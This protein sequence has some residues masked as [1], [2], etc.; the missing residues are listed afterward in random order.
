MPRYWCLLPAERRPVGERARQR[1]RD[2]RW[3]GSP[4]R[5]A[6]GR[7]ATTR[8]D[9]R[10]F[11]DGQS[12]CCRDSATCDACGRCSGRDR[13]GEYA[14]RRRRRARTHRAR[15]ARPCEDARDRIRQPAVWPQRPD[16]CPIAY[17]AYEAPLSLRVRARALRR[18]AG[19]CAGWDI[20]R[21]RMP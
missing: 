20:G 19:R 16:A 5:G 3:R 2:W 12:S 21:D 13:S 8:A 18:H 14:L 15:E 7:R 9:G 4:G 1:A 11:R 17:D 10:R 6:C